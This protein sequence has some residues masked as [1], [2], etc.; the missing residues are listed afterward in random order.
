MIENVDEKR[1]RLYDAFNSFSRTHWSLMSVTGPAI[2]GSDNLADEQRWRFPLMQTHAEAGTFEL[3]V[4]RRTSRADRP[5]MSWEVN[6]QGRR[7]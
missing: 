5:G 4:E 1:L 6:E 3:E 2:Q 7:S